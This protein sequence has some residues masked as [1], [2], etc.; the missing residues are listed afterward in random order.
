MGMYCACGVKIS[1]PDYECKPKC[2]CEWDGWI[3]TCDWPPER[4]NKDTPIQENPKKSGIYLTRFSTSCG[5]R[6][7]GELHFSLEPFKTEEGGYFDRFK[8]DCH[9]EGESWE[10]GGPYAWKEVDWDGKISN[11]IKLNTIFTAPRDGLYHFHW[12]DEK[13][14]SK[15]KNL[16]MIK[17]ETFRFPDGFQHPFGGELIA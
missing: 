11:D 3:S 1:G 17:G 6:I 2:L 7:E 13:R 14:K 9:W 16:K 10:E 12:Y 15:Q 8:Y 4:K 5:D